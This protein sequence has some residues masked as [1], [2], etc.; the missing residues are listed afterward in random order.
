MQTRD[1]YKG[2]VGKGRDSNRGTVEISPEL[3][4]EILLSQILGPIPFYQRSHSS[5]TLERKGQ[6]AIRDAY[7]HDKVQAGLQAH[8][9]PS[10][11]LIA[12]YLNVSSPSVAFAPASHSDTSLPNLALAV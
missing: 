12:S 1:I 2:N 6:M 7:W 8:L 9:V 3:P 4:K 10:A 11:L 5:L